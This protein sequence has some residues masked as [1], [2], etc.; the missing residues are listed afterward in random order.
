MLSCSGRC[1]HGSQSHK[2]PGHRLF[3]CRHLALRQTKGCPQKHP[4]EERQ[5]TEAATEEGHFRGR[6]DC[7]GRELD[8]DCVGLFSTSSMARDPH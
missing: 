8:R 1:A 3:S 4:S 6:G 2:T 5:P 7:G